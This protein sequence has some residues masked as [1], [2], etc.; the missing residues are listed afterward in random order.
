MSLTYSQYVTELATMAVI[1]PADPDFLSNLPST[2]DDAEQRLYRELDLL[3]TVTRQT[4]MMST[5]TRT[6][7]LPT[8]SGRFVVTNGFNVI[9]PASQ[10]NPD[11]GT[12][13]QLV[14]TSRDVLDMLYCRALLARPFRRFTP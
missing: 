14:P 8:T 1:D 13:N 7:N 11:G 5:G 2:I 12:R 3:S 10:S 4:G 6:F 9:T